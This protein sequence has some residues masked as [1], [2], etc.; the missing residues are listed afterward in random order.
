[1][2]AEPAAV[3]FVAAEGS[4]VVEAEVVQRTLHDMSNV[5]MTLHMDQRRVEVGAEADPEH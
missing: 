5:G 3:E 2:T 1:M 4:E